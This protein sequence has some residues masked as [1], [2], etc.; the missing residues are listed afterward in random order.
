MILKPQNTKKLLKGEDIPN[1][2]YVRDIFL[3]Y[4][5]KIIV[6]DDDPYYSIY[7][8]EN[9]RIL[10]REI[11]ILDIYSYM[12]ELSAMSKKELRKR[13]LFTVVQ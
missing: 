9:D 8:I 1:G 3:F 13:I 11:G 2:P 10:A 12:K 4:D 7:Y 6:Y 5:Y